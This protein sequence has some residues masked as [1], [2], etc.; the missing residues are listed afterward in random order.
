ML[1][2]RPLTGFGNKSLCACSLIFSLRIVAGHKI[3]FSE[4]CDND[5][6]DVGEVEHAERDDKTLDNE[7]HE[8]L[9]KVL[10]FLPLFMRRSN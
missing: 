5:V 7:E 10:K 2:R 6:G 9:R 4:S 8:V 1:V 3:K